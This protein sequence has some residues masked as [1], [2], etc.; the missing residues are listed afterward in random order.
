MN[1]A[2]SPSTTESDRPQR[3]RER[4]VAVFGAG[5]AGLTAAHELSRL[6]Y[7]VEVYEANSEAGG[8]FRSAR[9]GEDRNMPSE[10][11]WHGMGPWYHNVFDVMRQI[12]FDASGSMYDRALSRPIDFGIFPDRGKA[13]FYDKRLRSVPPMFEMAG[14]DW[15]HWSWLMLKTWASRRRTETYYSML[16]AAEQWKA[17][18][19][20]RSY[21]CWRSCFGPWIGSDWTRVSLHTAGQFFRKQLIGRA[22]YVHRA[23]DEGPAW[24]H[25]QG[26]GWLLLRGP[27]SEVWFGPWVRHLT[28]CGVKFRWNVPLAKLHADG[29]RIIAAELANGDRVQSDFYVIA[30]NPF[31]AAAIVARST[32]LES[33]RETK[34]FAPL[35]QDGPHTQVSLRIAFDEPIRFPRPRVAVVLA[36]SEFNLTLFAQEQA[37]RPEVELGDRVKS[38][39]TV[40]ACASGV[41]GRLYGLPLESCTKEQFVAEVTE[42]ILRCGA[43]DSLV[44]QANGGRS[45]RSFPILKTEVWHEWEFCPSGIRFLYPKWV[46]TTRTQSHLP[47]QTTSIANLFLAG[48]H[49]K[50]AADVW[51]IEGAVE[52]GRRAAR[53]IDARVRVI[54]Q[55][56]PPWLRALGRLDDVCF[57]VGAPHF[58]SLLLVVPLLTSILSK[59]G[60]P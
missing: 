50:T 56:T 47:N 26:D 58:L 14:P 16:N 9:R 45:L 31:S 40:T 32:G 6:G 1:P 38:L 20:P 27:S 7:A 23:D 60:S 18:L 8:F 52:S 46:T 10:Y 17:V 59:K 34:K 15:V 12:P 35:I 48:A 57:G 28:G 53:G 43:L 30:T 33:E 19:R 11:S 25:G 5:I 3:R 44:R 42:Q 2:P 21:A 36:D 4:T 29:S 55:Y 22:S 49:T 39:W 51:S 54:E 13:Q 41:P 24:C 37:W